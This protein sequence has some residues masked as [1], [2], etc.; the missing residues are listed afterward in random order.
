MTEVIIWALGFNKNSDFSEEEIQIMAVFC[1]FLFA[2]K[3]S[4]IGIELLE[5]ME[6]QY[7][8]RP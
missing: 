7:F 3:V 8:P 4:V 1:N 5:D 6:L 2:S